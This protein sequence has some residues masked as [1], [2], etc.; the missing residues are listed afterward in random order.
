MGLVLSPDNNSIWFAEIIG[1]K[2]GSFDIN[3]KTM[4]E[5]STG[6]LTGPT[7]LTFDSIGRLWITMSYSSNILMAEPG[8]LIPRSRTNG[9][10][11]FNLDKPDS[12]SPF[13]IAITNHNANKLYLSDHGSS[14]VIVSNLSSELRIILHIGPRHRQHILCRCQVK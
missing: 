10:F 12:I 8:L 2:I 5:F 14:R 9:M 1:D 11:E 4:R 13:G 6:E 3:S 7:L